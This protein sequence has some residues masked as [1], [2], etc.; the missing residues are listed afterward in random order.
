MSSTILLSPRAQLCTRYCSNKHTLGS[1]AFCFCFSFLVFFSDVGRAGVGE[2]ARRASSNGECGCRRGVQGRRRTQRRTRRPQ[3]RRSARGQRH[4][5]S[6]AQG[7][8]QH[9]G[10]P[11]EM[12]AVLLVAESVAMMDNQS[13]EGSWENCEG[14]KHLIL[15]RA[16]EDDLMTAEH[17][18][19]RWARGWC[20][21]TSTRPRGR[22]GNDLCTRPGSPRGL[23]VA[24]VVAQHAPRR[25][26]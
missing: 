14:A 4:G 2:G 19:P 10:A 15:R 23:G 13:K 1:F 24:R 8:A 12:F 3:R 21:T 22:V 11:E 25:T 6:G 17:D 18:V 20:Q 5:S 7:H 9:V 26:R 16:A